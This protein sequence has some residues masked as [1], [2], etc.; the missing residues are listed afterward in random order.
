M[1]VE[2]RY[3]RLCPAFFRS[4]RLIV[5][6]QTHILLNLY[7]PGHLKKAVGKPRLGIERGRLLPCRVANVMLFCSQTNLFPRC[8]FT[9]AFV[10]PG[11]CQLTREPGMRRLRDGDPSLLLLAI[12]HCKAPFSFTGRISIPLFCHSVPQASNCGKVLRSWYSPILF[13]VPCIVSFDWEA[14]Q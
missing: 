11:A 12:Q 4:S 7:M 8:H 9:K 6:W 3:E 1:A 2:V 13:H 10:S 14:R 5:L